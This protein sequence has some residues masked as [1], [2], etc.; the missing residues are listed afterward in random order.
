MVLP[1]VGY[2]SPVLRQQ[3][4]EIDKDYPE[5]KQ[6]IDDMFETMHQADGIGLAAPQ[7][8]KSISL[9]VVDL[10]PLAEDDPS[11]E[12]YRK[13]YINPRIVE[14]IGELVPYTEGCLSVPDIHEDVLRAPKVV[15]EY[16]NQQWELVEEQLEGIRAR[17]V[18]HEYDHLEG[19]IFTDRVSAL[20]KRLLKGRLAN[21]SNGKASPRYKMRF[22]VKQKL[23][24]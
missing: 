4:S 7:I 18:Q 17:V 21:I 12:G 1:I 16:Y 6:L 10:S 23:E 9:F 2:G 24:S 22:G 19:V 15:I 5:L 14:E 13:V 20:K 3:A 8:G 11:L